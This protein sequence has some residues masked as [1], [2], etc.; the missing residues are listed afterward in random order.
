MEDNETTYAQLLERCEK[1]IEA[2]KTVKPE[3]FDGKE[4]TE[5]V[6]F[7]GKYKFTG[8]TYLQRFGV[9]LASDT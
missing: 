9:S 6:L 5:I 4:G 8:V 2:L 7:G 3:D 1:T